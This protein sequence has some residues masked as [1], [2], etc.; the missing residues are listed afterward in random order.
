MTRP[1]VGSNDVGFDRVG[2]KTLFVGGV[3]EDRGAVV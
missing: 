2:D 3:L 1:G